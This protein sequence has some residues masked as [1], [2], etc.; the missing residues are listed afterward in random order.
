MKEDEI[1][2]RVGKHVRDEQK[3][4]AR[5]E[6]IARG[7]ASPDE[8][9]DLEKAAEADPELAARLEASRPF[10]EVAIARIATNASKKAAAPEAKTATSAAKTAA[11]AAKV[12]AKPS[13]LFR[14][15]ATIAAP[16]ALAAA[17]VLYFSNGQ[18]GP[19]LPGY[20]ISATSEQAMRGP[21]GPD[22]RIHVG[23][24]REARFEIVARPATAS[25][26]K[27]VAYAFVI[28]EGSKAEPLDAKIDVSPDGAIKV[29]G[30][31]RALDGAREVRIVIGPPASIGKFDD[32][33]A[34]AA[35][36]EKS[37]YVRVLSVAIDR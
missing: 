29:T 2:A 10:D 15:V 24:S 28:L 34:L 14:R 20:E 17:L 4:D 30:Q 21:A 7:D 6:R 37:S 36:N 11:P 22:T 8:V 32:A 35:K 3:D 12:T 25:P 31:A 1:L 9:A 16:L 33:A 19:E 23:T 27:V 26:A 18:R 13:P 5:F